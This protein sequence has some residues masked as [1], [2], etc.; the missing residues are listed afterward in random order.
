MGVPRRFAL[1]A[2]FALVLALIPGM[3]AANH[4]SAASSAW[5]VDGGDAAN[6]GSSSVVGPAQPTPVWERTY[7]NYTVDGIIGGTAGGH[8]RMVTDNDGNLLVRTNLNDTDPRWTPGTVD[9]VLASIDPVDGSINWEALDTAGRDAGA[10]CIPAVAPDG[11]IYT[12]NQDA[13]AGQTARLVGL[14]PATG[15]ALTEGTLVRRGCT[16]S[17]QFTH[18]GLLLYVEESRNVSPPEFPALRAFSVN[19]GTATQVWE[20]FN[21][22]EGVLGVTDTAPLQ[23]ESI[24]PVVADAGTPAAGGVYWVEK[25]TPADAPSELVLHRLDSATGQSV[26]SVVVPGQDLNSVHADPAG[27]VIVSTLAAGDDDNDGYLYRYLDNGTTL[28]P[29]WSHDIVAN[30]DG[31]RLRA[32]ISPRMVLAGDK[33]VSWYRSPD[34]IFG[35]DWRT[36]DYTWEFRP[37][38]AGGFSTT[39]MLVADRAGN[40]YYE[41]FGQEFVGSVDTNGRARGTLRELNIGGRVG[42]FAFTPDGE[43]YVARGG[44]GIAIALLEE[45]IDLASCL[46]RYADVSPDQTHAGA[47]CSVSLAQIAG[48]FSDGTFRPGDPVTRAQMATFIAKAAFPGETSSPGDAFDDVDPS[49]V[50]A[51]AIAKLVDE[52]IVSGFSDGSFRPNDP[53][54]R[55]QTATFIGRASGL[56][57]P[58][59]NGEVDDVS[60]DDVHADAIALLLD[61]GIV[62]GFPDGTFRPGDAVTRGQMA[63]FIARAGEAGYIGGEVVNDL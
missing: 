32:A 38:G 40:V 18:E 36:G 61:G 8:A 41:T 17:L 10:T 5:P 13:T 44:N 49:N 35:L 6:R 51:G 47:I 59:Y 28:T 23:R 58:A 22:R 15:A 19:A 25:R 56:E 39:D 3:A 27:G 30:S 42:Y 57:F 43:L 4:T 26:T 9:H 33:L 29:S 21:T 52:G 34:V 45:G 54:T 53:V 46:A 12:F 16:G 63:T 50:H 24:R 1:A 31:T 20:R 62:G 7:S 48:G 14:D 11:T 37:T 60:S 2:T 55:G